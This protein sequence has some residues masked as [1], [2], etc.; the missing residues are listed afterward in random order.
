MSSGIATP[1]NWPDL[2]RITESS[3]YLCLKMQSIILAMQFGGGPK[4]PTFGTNPNLGKN[5]VVEKALT[6]NSPTVQ[7]NKKQ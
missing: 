2:P 5:S 4:V 7:F 1:V 3:T 6:D